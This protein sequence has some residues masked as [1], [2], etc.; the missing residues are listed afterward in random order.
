[1][2]LG[3][4]ISEIFPYGTFLSCV[5]I[6][7]LSKYP[8]FNKPPLPWTIPGYAPAYYWDKQHANMS[9]LI[10]GYALLPENDVFNA[11]RSV[12][13]ERNHFLWYFWIVANTFKTYF[14]D[15]SE[16]SENKHLFWDMFKTPERRHL[17]NIFSEM[18]LKRLK[19]LTKK[20]SFL[21][22]IWDVLK[23]SQKRHLFLDVFETPSRR[24]KKVVSFEMFLRGL[25]DVSLNGDLFETSQRHLL[26]AGWVLLQ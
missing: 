21:R 8:Y 19:E 20:T 22:C 2:Y 5:A 16:T 11:H 18:Y 25:W 10:N 15:I 12:L 26:P 1:M 13:S 14:W 23:R 4:K 7:C 6:K 9:R 24:L 17:K 3:K